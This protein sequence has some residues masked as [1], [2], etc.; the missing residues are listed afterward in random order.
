MTP[1]TLWWVPTFTCNQKLLSK[2]DSN[3]NK[4]LRIATG[5]T[6]PTPINALLDESGELPQE[7]RRKILVDLV[8]VDSVFISLNLKL[9]F[10]CECMIT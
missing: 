5:A 6:K 3:Q 1:F 10:H 7:V 2:L 9:S 8:K 4:V